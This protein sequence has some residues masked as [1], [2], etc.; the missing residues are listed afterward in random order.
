MMRARHI[1]A[2]MVAA[3]LAGTSPA[4]A[5]PAPATVV[6]Q[7]NGVRVVDTKIGT[8]IE[9]QTG[10]LVVVHYT[11]WLYQDGAKGAQFD[12]SRE[13]GHPFVFNLG[14]GEVIEGWDTGL[15]GMK[16]GGQRT[17]IIPP[18]AGYGERGAGGVIGPNATLLFEI[19]LLEVQ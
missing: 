5:A 10:S 14:G 1:C 4:M 3:L 15:V 11:G 6:V 2:A 8:G 12:T 7:S 16:V 9:A 18:A 19:E 17:L 13:R